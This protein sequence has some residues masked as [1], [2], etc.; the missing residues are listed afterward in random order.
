LIWLN[1][2]GFGIDQVSPIWSWS[3]QNSHGPSRVGWTW[4]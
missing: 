3:N 2:I 4:L 1:F